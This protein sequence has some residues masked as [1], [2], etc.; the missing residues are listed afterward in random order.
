M[1]EPLSSE[2]ILE[3]PSNQ[4][5]DDVDQDLSDVLKP[6]KN[7]RKR[8]KAITYSLHK[9][10]ED[11]NV[12]VKEIKEGEVNGDTWIFKSQ[13][14]EKYRYYC[15]YL[16][17]GC[18][19]ALYLHLTD[20]TKGNCFIADDEH[21]NHELEQEISTSKIDA[22]IYEKI[23][24]LENLGIKPDG[25]IK[26]LIKSGFQPPKKTTLNNIL[27][28]IRK[29]KKVSNQPT[30][31]DLKNWCEKYNDIPG[32]ED[33]VFVAEFE[34][35]AFPHQQFRVLL[36]T[37]R[38]LK[39]ALDAKY[40]LSD[41]TYK[42]T[43]GGFPALTGGTT[44]KNKNF[45]PF[46]LALCSTE[47]NLDFAFFFR[48]IKSVCFR[49]YGHTITPTI[50]VADS[51]DAITIGFKKVFEMSK[52]V[53][54]WAHVIRNIDKRLLV[55]VDTIKKSIRDDICNIQKIFREDL[56]LHATELFKKKWEEKKNSSI[57]EFVE[58]FLLQWVAKDYGWY[59]GYIEDVCFPTTSN[60]LES[61][62]DKIKE[63]L[64]HKR[65]GLIEFLNECRSN[66]IEH[67]SR[68]RSETISTFNPTTNELVEF[69][70]LNLKKF[71]K[72]PI[73]TK[74]DLLEA[75]TWNKLG[76]TI[77]RVGEYYMVRSGDDNKSIE[78]S[79]EDCK[80][81]LQRLDKKPW[82]N[83]NEMINDINSIRLIKMNTENWK[84]STCTCVFW[85]KHYK[86][87]HTISVAYRLKMVDFNII[88]M[89]LPISNKRKK[90]ASK[91]NLK[92]LQHQP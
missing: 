83:F 92:S 48:T 36:T 89:D 25:I 15:K 24:E 75:H 50:L 9:S 20:G 61:S 87:S 51:A 37:R 38:L 86:C 44:D 72:E 70:N 57:N 27:K 65:L 39:N 52:R 14:G 68:E 69:E 5:L 35:Q 49:V 40:I 28:S 91:K 88:F 45:H 66:L 73:I 23:V 33:T 6:V 64:K 16:K 80:K 11:Y 58:Y 22:P 41:A 85:L 82:E 34:C 77:Q 71:H 63:A 1:S 55:F 59:E 46:G 7:T 19:A 4:S 62:H 60:G 18:R 76:K 84:N 78:L 10:F 54:C 17:Q 43:Y 90:G 32:D 21:S 31:N 81:F 12:I 53:N 26:N 42:L 74:E 79:R 13:D 8:G 2:S 3:N 47:N 29:T 30:L 56:F 67:W